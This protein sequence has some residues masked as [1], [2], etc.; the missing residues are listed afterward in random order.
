MRM[1]PVVGRDLLVHNLRVVSEPTV[2]VA[3]TRILPM[4][5]MRSAGLVLGAASL[6]TLGALMVGYGSALGWVVAGFF[7]VGGLFAAVGLVRPPTLRLD[8]DGFTLRE[9]FRR[10]RRRRWADCSPFVV[11]KRGKRQRLGVA[12]ASDEVDW[13]PLR[14]VNTFLAGGHETI[15]LGYGAL[16]AEELAELL[17]GYR[18]A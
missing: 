18:L 8:R 12:Y 16:K 6:T 1:S 3:E 2:P 11:W 15:R 10:P 7:G 9:S 5:R 14:A 13:L 4:S 17:N